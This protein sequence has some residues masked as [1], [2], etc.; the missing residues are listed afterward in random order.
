MQSGREHQDPFVTKVRDFLSAHKLAPVGE[1][2]VV[3]V[4]GGADSVALLAVLRELATRK[5][6]WRL[7]VAHLNHQLRDQADADAD[8]VSELA[9]KWSLDFEIGSCDVGSQARRL[10]LGIEEAGRNA[11][12]EF[13]TS[14]AAKCEASAVALGHTADDNVETVLHRIVRGTH[15]RGL[16]GIP[17]ARPIGRGKARIIRP[18]LGCSREEV[19]AYCKR[20]GLAWRIDASN[21]ATD[22]RR[23]F[24]RHKLLALLTDKLNMRAGQALTRLAASAGQ[25]ED[26]LCEQASKVMAS[27]VVENGPGQTAFEIGSLA[28]THGVLLGY[29]ARLAMEA[30]GLSLGRVSSEQISTVAAMLSGAGPLAICLPGGYVARQTGGQV[31]IESAGAAPVAI[32]GPVPLRCP[33]D[34]DIGDGR[35][36]SCRLG[37]LNLTRFTENCRSKNT[38]VEMMDADQLSGPLTCR[39]RKAG[40]AFRP[41]GCGGGQSVGD[42]LTNQ[43]APQWLRDQVRCVSDELGIVYLAPM[44]IDERAKV[45][46][47]TVTVL[48]IAASDLAR[49]KAGQ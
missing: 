25:V 26:Y 7:T 12:Y 38:G 19:E 35:V 11:R 6:K 49:P 45:T 5:R 32:A 42:F 48:E 34:T 13:L 33:G 27:A 18:L 10:G 16:A 15:L 40:D 37:P 4:S 39:P 14:V 46:P 22:Y 21:A 2:I 29:V 44:R 20:S 3:A 23:N 8:F 28:D 41:L 9:R 31:V 30:Q 24:I 1:G 17:V 43:K 47:Q 36:I